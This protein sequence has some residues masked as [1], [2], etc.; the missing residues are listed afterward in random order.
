MYEQNKNSTERSKILVVYDYHPDEILQRQ[1]ALELKKENLPNV[2]IVRYKGKYLPRNK[3]HTSYHIAKFTKKYLPFDYLLELHDSPSEDVP[4]KRIIIP[5]FWYVYDSK[6]PI[7]KELDEEFVRYGKELKIKHARWARSQPMLLYEKYSP[8]KYA[9]INI[10]LFSK[11]VTKKD[12]VEFLKG[13]VEILYRHPI[14]R[15]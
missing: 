6:I 9:G 8:S 3:D 13:L 14:G 10:E 4:Q 7:T 12:S 1:V 2:K 11:Y 5:C 15:V